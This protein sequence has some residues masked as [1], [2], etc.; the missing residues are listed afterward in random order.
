MAQRQM[1]ADQQHAIATMS[2]KMKQQQLVQLELESVETMLRE[3]VKTQ[4]ESYQ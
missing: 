3:Q 2:S 1:I 4:Q